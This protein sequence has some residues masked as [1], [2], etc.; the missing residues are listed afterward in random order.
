MCKCGHFTLLL[1]GLPLLFGTNPSR[2]GTMHSTS[3]MA[4][5]DECKT[6]HQFLMVKPSEN[7][8]DIWNSDCMLTSLLVDSPVLEEKSPPWGSF[9]GTGRPQMA[10][11]DYVLSGACWLYSE[12]SKIMSRPP[13]LFFLVVS[14][15]F[16]SS[17]HLRSIGGDRHREN[18][19]R[20]T[21][22]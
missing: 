2:T 8:I 19:G 14:Y 5:F 7:L 9:L 18:E 10:E 16:T 17:C 3:S 6:P 4:L 11:Q 1:P 20:R 22:S 21:F 15:G 13:S 12:A